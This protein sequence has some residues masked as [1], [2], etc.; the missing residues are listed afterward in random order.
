MMVIRHYRWTRGGG[1]QRVDFGADEIDTG[2]L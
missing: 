1:L 2:Q